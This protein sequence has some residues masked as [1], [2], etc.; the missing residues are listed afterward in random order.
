MS[1]YLNVGAK[2]HLTSSS[3]ALRNA[4]HPTLQHQKAEKKQKKA[5]YIIYLFIICLINRIFGKY[6]GLFLVKKTVWFKYYFL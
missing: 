3:K 1:S 5:E 2:K 4:K 6:D